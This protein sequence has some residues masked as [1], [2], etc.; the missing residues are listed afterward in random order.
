MRFPQAFFQVLNGNAAVQYAQQRIMPASNV[1]ILKAF[2]ILIQFRQGHSGEI[3]GLID[4]YSI[5]QQ[6]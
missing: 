5:F 3:I 4:L 2:V 6:L 1:G